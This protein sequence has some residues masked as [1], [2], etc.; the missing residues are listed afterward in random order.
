VKLP[1]GFDAVGVTFGADHEVLILTP[2]GN[3]YPANLVLSKKPTSVG[4]EYGDAK[5]WIY[6]DGRQA[7]FG[8]APVSCR[9]YMNSHIHSALRKMHSRVSAY[10]SDHKTRL[11]IATASAAPMSPKMIDQG[12]E[13]CWISGCNPDFNAYTGLPNKPI[14]KKDWIKHPFVYAGL[15]FHL[16]VWE[17]HKA[18]HFGTQKDVM[19][20]VK[21]EDR[22]AGLVGVLLSDVPS[23]KAR[24]KLHGKAGCYRTPKWGVEYRVLGGEL[25]R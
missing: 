22:I 1:K 13:E 25:L 16:S 15:H 7:E 18:K 23:N 14:R 2:G 17:G 9:E 24:R 5:E 21:I 12:G 4:R 20:F 6:H 10:N 3:G 11:H 8:H 19:D